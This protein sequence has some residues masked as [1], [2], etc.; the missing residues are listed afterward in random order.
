MERPRSECLQKKPSG[1]SV[2]IRGR[3][4]GPENTDA[5]TRGVLLVT[6][7]SYDDV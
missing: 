2:K 1:G 5:K 4:L 6:T 7:R 3:L